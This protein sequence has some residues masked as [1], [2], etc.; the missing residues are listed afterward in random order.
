MQKNKTVVP[1]IDVDTLKSL[2]AA[3]CAGVVH[4]QC[5]HYVGC[6]DCTFY[7]G[8]I[9]EFK[10]YIKEKVDTFLEEE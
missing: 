4:Q 2:Q 10:A 8:N 5:Y 7:H 9:E 3:L 1:P 6:D